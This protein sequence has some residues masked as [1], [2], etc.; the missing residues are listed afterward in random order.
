M[1]PKTLITEST[2]QHEA[3]AA[4]AALTRH[5]DKPQLLANNFRCA[6]SYEASDDTYRV[7]LVFGKRTAEATI[8]PEALEWSLERFRTEVLDPAARRLLD[9]AN[10]SGG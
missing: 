9:S 10:V 5:K 1:D 6:L 3:L 2:I 8:R 7:H 4:F